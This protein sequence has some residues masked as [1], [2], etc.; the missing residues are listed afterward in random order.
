MGGGEYIRQV[1]G[2]Q[3]G[4]GLLEFVECISFKGGG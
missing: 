2:E 4:I 3:L 1:C